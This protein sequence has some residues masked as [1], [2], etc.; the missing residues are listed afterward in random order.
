M[1]P[2]VPASGLEPC[3]GNYYYYCKTALKILALKLFMRFAKLHLIEITSAKKFCDLNK[4][5]FFNQFLKST[6][7]LRYTRAADHAN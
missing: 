3:G 5:R 7:F 4:T 1:P 2:R 6:L